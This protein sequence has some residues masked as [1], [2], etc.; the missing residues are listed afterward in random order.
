[1]A[2]I[3]GNC[4]KSVLRLASNCQKSD[5]PLARHRAGFFYTL[6]KNKKKAFILA[7]ATHW[8]RGVY[9]RILPLSLSIYLMQTFSRLSAQEQ[10]ELYTQVINTK[11]RRF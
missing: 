10:Q 11:K 4:D 2:S 3:K 6:K 1:M 9:K 5:C 7:L 8:Q